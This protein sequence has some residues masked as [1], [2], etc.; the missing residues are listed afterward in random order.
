[1]PYYQGIIYP[2][3]CANCPLQA[4]VKVPPDGQIPAKIAIIGEGPG[5]TE[6]A[7][8][9]GFVGP[10]GEL[11]WL[12]ADQAGIKREDVWVTNAALC[13]PR[14]VKLSSGAVLNDQIVLQISARC[15]RLRLL[16]EL[17]YVGVQVLVPLGKWALKAI[18][19]LQDPKI[20]SYR[21]GVLQTDLADLANRIARVI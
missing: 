12:L 6:K 20:F 19:E 7:N 21:G 3:D 18:T 2:P 9:R 1:M 15:C 5:A 10:S 16:Y 4:D 11:L 13:Q 14:K 8:G 17:Q